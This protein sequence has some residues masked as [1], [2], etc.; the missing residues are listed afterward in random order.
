[1]TVNISDKTI[2]M[3][4]IVIGVLF[5]ISVGLNVWLLTKENKYKVVEKT[6]IREV[7]DT[8]HDTIPQIKYEKIIAYKKD[9]LKIV[10]TIPGDT[11]KIVA[12]IPVTQKEYSDDSTYTAW[13]SGYKP[14]LDSIDIYK[15]TVYIDHT[16]TKTKRQKFVVGP[17]VGVGYDVKHNNFAPTIGVGITYNLFGF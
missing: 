14:N 5:L 7:R 9:T 6:V 10:D 11:V 2:K 15:K 3:V 4:Q 12:E 16:I 17:Q 8:I 1:M 13:V